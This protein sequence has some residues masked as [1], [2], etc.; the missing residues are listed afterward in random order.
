MSLEDEEADEVYA[1]YDRLCEEAEIDD[2]D[3]TDEE[4]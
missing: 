3:D 2:E 4:E 1:E